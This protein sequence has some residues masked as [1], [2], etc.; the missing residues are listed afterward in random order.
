MDVIKRADIQIIAD[1]LF[2][3]DPIRSQNNVVTF[4]QWVG[5][6]KLEQDVYQQSGKI[7]VHWGKDEVLTFKAESLEQ[8][9]DQLL[10]EWENQIQV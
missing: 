3:S 2:E 5:G 1:K 7:T 6:Q 4:C 8:E 10:K 9:I